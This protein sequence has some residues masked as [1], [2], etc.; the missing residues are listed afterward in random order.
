[1][2]LAG[3]GNRDF[4]E[5]RK[6]GV[7]VLA[8]GTES[9]GRRPEGSSRDWFLDDL[10]ELEGVGGGCGWKGAAEDTS[11]GRRKLSGEKSRCGRGSGPHFPHPV[12][13]LIGEPTQ[14]P[15]V[16]FASHPTLE[17]MTGDLEKATEM[18]TTL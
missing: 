11:P 14:P 4:I 15:E 13:S 8:T 5:H 2:L 18:E 6:S 3:T 12:E 7:L 10:V 16:A 17:G 1:M 9:V